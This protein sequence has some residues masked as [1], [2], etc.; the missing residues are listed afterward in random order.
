MI[1]SE[2]D[3]LIRISDFKSEEEADDFTALFASIDVVTHEEVSG[4]LGD[5]VITL[6]LFVLIAH[7]FKHMK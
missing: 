3:N 1:A 4:I 2:N 6:I 7:F 5:D